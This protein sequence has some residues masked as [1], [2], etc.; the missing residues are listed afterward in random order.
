V[1]PRRPIA[2]HRLSAKKV[3]TEATSA[4]RVTRGECP[5]RSSNQR[6]HQNPV[7]HVTPAVAMPG[8]KCSSRLAA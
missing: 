2:R 1:A 4:R 6:A 3:A 5:R 8:D 7:I